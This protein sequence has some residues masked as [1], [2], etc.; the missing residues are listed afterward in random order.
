HWVPRSLRGFCI[1]FLCPTLTFGQTSFDMLSLASPDASSMIS[2][3]DRPA[4]LVA[5][6]MSLM[7]ALN[8]LS[9]A[10]SVTVA[11]SPSDLSHEDLIVTCECN[12][13]SVGEALEQ[14][15]QFSSFDYLAVHDQVVIYS[16]PGS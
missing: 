14:I 5:H 11:Y 10:A 7:D 2:V 13:A 16:L 12:S 9:Y 3:L 15:L 1:V 8:K 4:R 6:E